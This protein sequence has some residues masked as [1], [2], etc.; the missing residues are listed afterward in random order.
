MPVR[1]E[2]AGFIDCHPY[3]QAHRR[4]LLLVNLTNPG[5]WRAPVDEVI[6][7]GPI[8]VSVR[9]PMGGRVSCVRLLVSRQSVRTTNTTGWITLDISRID[10]HEV[11]VV[12][13]VQDRGA[14][15]A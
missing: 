5:S 15:S 11:A 4:A 8:R 13:T 6:P 1:V 3:R 7:A 9:P 10:D 12:G 2:G 14:H